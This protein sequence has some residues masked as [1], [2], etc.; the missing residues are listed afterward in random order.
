[1]KRNHGICYDG[2]IYVYDED[3]YLVRVTHSE[4]ILQ[5]ESIKW[6]DGGEDTEQMMVIHYTDGNSGYYLRGL[7]VPDYEE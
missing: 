6:K 2:R 1:M 4:I 3:T 5:S 7:I